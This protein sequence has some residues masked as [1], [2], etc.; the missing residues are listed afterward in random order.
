MSKIAYE[1]DL[2]SSLLHTDDWNKQAYQGTQNRPN[3]RNLIG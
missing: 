2:F 1:D 3:L